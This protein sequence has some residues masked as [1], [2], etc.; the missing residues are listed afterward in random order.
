VVRIRDGLDDLRVPFGHPPEHKERR[1]GVMAL[2]QLQKPGDSS[3]DA[4]LELVPLRPGNRCFE[5]GNLEI[6]FD[7]DREIVLG[8]RAH[9]GRRATPVPF[10]RGARSGRS[11]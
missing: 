4:A 1:P 10:V 5:G 2:E 3:R 11:T 9:V 6:L 8:H 7:V